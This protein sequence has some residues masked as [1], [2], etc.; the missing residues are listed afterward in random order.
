MAATDLF[1]HAG[2]SY[3]VYCDYLF[4]WPVLNCWKRDQSSRYVIHVLARNFVDLGVPMRLRC[5]GGPQF[6]SRKTN[7]FAV[8]WGKEI[9]QSI[10]YFS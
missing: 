2:H 4:G 7:D 9:Q 3:L 6:S 5:D 1:S 8:K 10:Q